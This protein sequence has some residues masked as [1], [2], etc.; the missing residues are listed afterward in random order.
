MVPSKFEISRGKVS[1]EDTRPALIFNVEDISPITRYLI[2]LDGGEPIEFVDEEETGIYP[3]EQIEPGHHTAIVEAFDSAGNSLITTFSFDIEAFE[4]PTFTEY[5]SRIATDVIPLFMGT[6]RPD[7]NILVT[8]TKRSGESQEYQVE[9][10]EDGAFVVIPD[11]TFGLGVYDVVAIATE[12]DGR[13]SEPSTPVRFVV[14]NP[15]YIQIGSLALSVLSI[16][17]PIIALLILLIFGIWY[18]WHRL[19]SWQKKIIKETKEAEYR[20]A[21]EFGAITSHM[22]NNI[23]KLKRS[24]RG[25]LTKAEEKLVEELRRDVE[26]ARERINKEIGDIDDVVK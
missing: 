24:R 5:P 23:K 11:G 8:I 20:L 22:T 3:L 18:L 2:Q 4:K 16:L 17:V 6:T 25:K 15:G 21:V 26:I 7:A 13:M 10:N 9:S 12:K 1:D 19:Q 14:E